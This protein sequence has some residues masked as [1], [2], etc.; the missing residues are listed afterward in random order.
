V[1]HALLLFP[2]GAGYTELVHKPLEEGI[3]PK[4]IYTE[5]DWYG[6][7]Y[8]HIKPV[9]EKGQTYY[10]LLGWDGAAAK[11]NFRVLDALTLDKKGRAEFGHQVFQTQ[12]GYANR[13]VFE[14]AKDAKMMLD[15]LPARA[16]I[17]FNDLAPITGAAEGNYA[18]YGPSGAYHAYALNDGQWQL[19]E[20]IDMSRP[21]SE[22]E[23]PQFNFP[24]RPDLNKIRAPENPLI[25]K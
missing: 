7:L 1:Y 14:Y 8:Y 15:W 2:G 3:D 12:D 9:K 22:E 6:A 25:G 17:V 24:A 18:F 16:S 21:K 20:Y 13:R 4:R 11:S 23:K 10:T 5:K 19:E